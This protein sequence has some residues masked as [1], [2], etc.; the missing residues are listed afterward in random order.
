MP[1]PENRAFSWPRRL[2]RNA[3]ARALALVALGVAGLWVVIH[4]GG[5]LREGDTYALDGALLRALRVSGDPHQAI[6]P[7]WLT[8]VLRDVTA[9]GSPTIIAFVTLM[10]A[11]ALI[12]RQLWRRALVL[13]IVCCSA[14][15]SDDLLKVVYHRARPGYAVAGLYT[16]L[17]SFPSGHST[18]TAALWLTLAAIAASLERRTDAKVFWFAMALAAILAV[19]FSR[20]FLGA[21]WPTDVLAGWILGAVWALIG[22]GAWRALPSRW[23]GEAR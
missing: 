7:P 19:G 23:R 17:Q 20:V 15:A 10:A 22:W 16:D 13:V 1:P 6:G 11:A 12:F 18:A 21:H 3:E 5:E 2:A 14:S 9:L 8:G 4:I